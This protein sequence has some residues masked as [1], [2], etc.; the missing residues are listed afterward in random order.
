MQPLLRYDGVM[1]VAA[2]T[3]LLRERLPGLSAVW[4]YGSHARGDARPD[5]DVDLAFLADAPSSRFEL[6]ALQGD[7][8]AAIGT[9]VDLVDL[10][11][12]DDVL[13]VQVI[14]H[15]HVVFERTPSERARF[16]MQAMSRYAY[17]NEER[18]EILDDI[19]G[20]GSI[21]G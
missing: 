6:L 2:A 17:L 19:L 16:E 11:T 13:R 12:A 4:L 9:E 20:R 15:G 5:S 1:D 14:E 21:Y 18:R 7:L 8:A 10:W 3:D